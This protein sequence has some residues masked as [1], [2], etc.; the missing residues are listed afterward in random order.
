MAVDLEQVSFSALALTKRLHNLDR[1]FFGAIF[2]AFQ[3]KHTTHHHATWKVKLGP[4]RSRERPN[5]TAT[6]NRA[7]IS[8]KYP[9]FLESYYRNGK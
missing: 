7:F 5:V 1:K 9:I 4:M 3:N 2:S 6:V 8:K